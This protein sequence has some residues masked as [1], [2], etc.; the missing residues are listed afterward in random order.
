MD[1]YKM[2]KNRPALKLNKFIF[3]IIF[4]LYSVLLFLLVVCTV[5]M[6]NTS[7]LK[8][9]EDVSRA[10][11]NCQ[12]SLK[13]E[14]QLI[15]NDMYD[16]YLNDKDF[17]ALSVSHSELTTY[18]HAYE[19]NN[20]LKNRMKI[21]G[22]YD[23][24]F[25]IYSEKGD[26]MFGYDINKIP[27]DRQKVLFNKLTELIVSIDGADN[28]YLLEFDGRTLCLCMIRD[29]IVS[30]GVIFDLTDNLQDLQ[31]DLGMN[32][33]TFLCMDQQIYGSDLLVPDMEKM[34]EEREEGTNFIERSNNRILC[35]AKLDKRIYLCAVVPLSMRVYMSYPILILLV[36]TLMVA[37]FAIYL[38]LIGKKILIRP[39]NEMVMEMNRIIDG[40]MD[41]VHV[42]SA[43]QEV[44]AVS[45]TINSMIDEVQKQK[46]VSYE[47]TIARQKAQMQYLSMQV[48]P[49]FYLNG[50]KSLNAYLMSGNRQEM[51]EMILEMS[52]Y[53]RYI[54]N[55]ERDFIALED[56]ISY[57]EIYVKLRQ[58]MTDRPV[59]LT[60]TNKAER[61]K[62]GIPPLTIQTFVEN[63]FK[64]AS[65]GQGLEELV[66]DITIK[67]LQMEEKT[68]MDLEIADNGQGYPEELLEG[69]NDD[70]SLNETGIGIRNLKQ[71]LR[72][73]YGGTV[74]YNFYNDGGAVSDLILPYVD[75]T[76]QKEE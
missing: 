5:Y 11:N 59:R 29:Q 41:K 40:N 10:M 4:T 48:K 35:G 8:M 33:E 57:V 55:I 53:M 3:V 17:S 20:K 22:S 72:L 19:L 27:G 14:I 45:N 70:C 60:V 26:R 46:M 1:Y 37:S 43:F 32:A 66:I 51:Q 23:G 44:W 13:Q 28:W 7:S 67:E 34:I 24:Y 74:E 31:A 68:W 18:N 6:L 38:Y 65:A 2:T 12:T 36:F 21:Y 30:A 64:Y 63:S 69:L 73:L 75:F 54:L 71:R 16:I 9:Q 76:S 58:K 25:L 39:L 52:D 62:W 56:E 50:L 47:E 15:E 49:H 42:Q 61:E